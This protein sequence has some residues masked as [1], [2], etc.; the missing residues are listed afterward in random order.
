M[1]KAHVV[2]IPPYKTASLRYIWSEGYANEGMLHQ[3]A[4]ATLS[5]RGPLVMP[6]MNI[7]GKTISKGGQLRL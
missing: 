7:T 2:K 5:K 3:G 1:W 6:R 4:A